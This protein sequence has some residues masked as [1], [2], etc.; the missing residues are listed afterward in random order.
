MPGSGYFCY[1]EEKEDCRG[2]LPANGVGWGALAHQ[3]GNAGHFV[4]AQGS[5]GH[6][7]P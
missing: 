7:I 3:Q 4:T 6:H 2:M 1:R 5:Y